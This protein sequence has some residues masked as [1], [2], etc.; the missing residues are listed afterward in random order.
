MIRVDVVSDTPEWLEERR[1]SLGASE[2][3]AVMGMSPWSTPLEIYKSKLGF[4]T[5]FNEDL[6]W[7]GHRSESLV[8]DWITERSGLGL[9]LEPHGFMARHHSLPLHASFDRVQLE[10]FL[11]VQIKTAHQYSGHKWDEGIPTDIRV[12]V[13]AEMLVAGTKS[14]LVVVLIG[15]REFR[16]FWET[17]DQVFAYEHML[18]GN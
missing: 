16:P 5:P 14:A 17:F 7:I 18:P 3:A 10:P 8:A 13:Q 1:N 15:G 9:K 11:T 2:V 6:A 4:D 12:Q